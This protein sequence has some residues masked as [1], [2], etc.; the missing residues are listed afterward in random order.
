VK[1]ALARA[2]SS[3]PKGESIVL[4]YQNGLFLPEGGTSNL[5]QVAR[6][7]KAEE[8]FLVLLTRFCGQGR[9]VSNKPT[10]QNYAPTE[11][12]R[13]EEA[14]KCRLKKSDFEQAM[15]DLFKADKIGIEEYG[16]PSR[17]AR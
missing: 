15:R 6:K 1:V 2:S 5:D 10:A 4:R 3:C 16:R 12:A 17:A 11:F 7:S 8:V 13:E 14:K 9:N